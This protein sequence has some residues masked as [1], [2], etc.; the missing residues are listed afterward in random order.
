MWRGS[1]TSISDRAL[2]V[3]IGLVQQAR[4]RNAEL[5][6]LDDPSQL[7]AELDRR[8]IPLTLIGVP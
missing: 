3:L 5:R 4:W 8:G 2:A 1:A 7:A 6:W